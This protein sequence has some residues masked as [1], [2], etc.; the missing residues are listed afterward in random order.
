MS[1]S[2]T[3]NKVKFHLTIFNILMLSVISLGKK[4]SFDFSSPP[5]KAFS[6]SKIASVKNSVLRANSS[7]TKR[8][9]NNYLISNPK[10]LIMQGKH[11][12]VVEFDYKIIK[13]AEFPHD[14]GYFYFFIRTPKGTKYD[15]WKRW[16][17]KDGAKGHKRYIIELPNQP[18]WRIYFGIKGQGIIELDKLKIGDIDEFDTHE[19]HTPL[20]I[21]IG[22][23]KNEPVRWSILQKSAKVM[24]GKD[25]NYLLADTTFDKI[26]TWRRY[27]QLAPSQ[28]GIKKNTCYSIQFDY[29]ILKSPSYFQL[30]ERGSH[31]WRLVMSWSGPAGYKGK[32]QIIFISDENRAS[33]LIFGMKGPGAIIIDNIVIREWKNIKQAKE[34]LKAESI[35][36]DEI[37]KRISKIKSEVKKFKLS[38]STNNIISKIKF[39][40]SKLGQSSLTITEKIALYK[41]LQNLDR[42][43]FKLR[44][45]NITKTKSYSAFIAFIDNSLRKIRRDAAYDYT[46]KQTN[47]VELSLAGNEY[48]SFQIVIIPFRNITALTLKFSDLKSADNKTIR[49]ENIKFY[50]VEYVDTKKELYPVKYVG[51]WPDPLE[52]KEQIDISKSQ[53]AQPLWVTVY[54]P[55]NTSSGKYTG[56]ITIS[57]PNLPDYKITLTIN[58]RNFALPKK[59]TF[60]TSFAARNTAGYYIKW[61]LAKRGDA[62]LENLDMRYRDALLEHKLSPAR[63]SNSKPKLIRKANGDYYVDFS[64]FDK[65][66]NH[67]IKRGINSFTFGGYWGW[68]NTM[69]GMKQKFIIWPEGQDKPEEITL[70]VLSE[71]F[72]KLMHDY[73]KS[74]AE[75]LEKKGCLDD[76]YCYIYDEPGKNEIEKVNQLLKILHEANARLKAIIPGIPNNKYPE[77]YSINI[78]IMCPLLPGIDSDK[79]KKL[80]ESG[81]LSWCYVCLNPRHP[82]PNFFV[83]YPSIDHRIIFWMSW[84]YN[85]EGLLYWQTTFWHNHNPWENI[86]TYTTTHGDGCLFYPSRTKPIKI[87]PSIRLE[88]IRDGVEDYEYF[89]ILK[90]TVKKIKQNKI[91]TDAKLLAQAES[92]LAVPDDI[93]HS[94]TD[95][96]KSPER[97]LK[98]RQQLSDI[99]EKLTNILEKQSRF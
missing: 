89:A 79:A 26:R 60:K 27:L 47:K 17:G 68:R 66:L 55:A 2:S 84:K 94:L 29:K 51:L 16:E 71:P 73:F 5:D 78:D 39:I 52:P 20:N 56:T 31:G 23:E 81:K 12:Y 86:E 4:Y 38:P 46:G 34:G 30:L 93:V 3:M 18:G 62:E 76:V 11:R 7:N 21:H 15:I 98:Y 6:I 99:I 35:S 33:P 53:Y 54:A 77:T 69:K 49:K 83:D 24:S 58:V 28:I 74:W 40:E 42:D 96:T 65:V 95:Y 85:V 9:W 48:E 36:R 88:N 57:A 80:Q 19:K 8:R 37:E 82:Y 70:D 97:I 63:I 61:G 72:K 43:I 87:V 45:I 64:E 59:A 14:H 92:M 75:Y 32:G 44:I 13:K 1:K 91:K 50:K 25:G 10:T 67:Y 22:F 90:R 41:T